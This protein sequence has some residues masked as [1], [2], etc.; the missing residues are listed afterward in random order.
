MDWSHPPEYTPGGFCFWGR[1]TMTILIRLFFTALLIPFGTMPSFATPVDL[2]HFLELPAAEVSPEEMAY[3]QGIEELAGGDLD[4]AENAFQAALAQRADYANALLGL[5]EIESRRNRPQAAGKRIEQAVAA[6]PDNVHAQLSLGRYLSSTGDY[7]G[8]EAA[9]LM[10]TELDPT[11]F[12]ARIDLADLYATQLNRPTEAVAAYR[13]AL[14][15]NPDH[16]GAHYAIGILL[17]RQGQTAEAEAM[18]TR[19]MQLEPANPLP[20]MGLARLYT[21]IGNPASALE[22]VDRALAIQPSLVQAGALRG[23]ILLAQGNQLAAS[24]QFDQLLRANPKSG[25]L[26]LRIGMLYQ[27]A[28]RI[29]AAAQAYRRAIRIDPSLA[30]AFNN[31]AWLAATEGKNLSQAEQ[32]A[33][34]AVTLAPNQPTFRDTLGWVY[35]AQGRL[36]DAEKTL[37]AAAKMAPQSSEIHYHLGRVYLDL[38]DKQ[39]ARQALEHALSL[40]DDFQ[41]SAEAR[42]LLEGL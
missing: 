14:D 17:A 40:S 28:G 12:R 3:R 34:R 33:R 10:A 24:Q 11:L 5:A 22:S 21:A 25:S 27:G 37:A 26:A 39:K 23:E 6:E 2:P 42:R 1:I 15:L 20:P 31:L 38:G 35:R 36:G 7:Q 13:A 9:L 41:E 30:L 4:G 29:E 19:A 8:A 16:A 32:W 18:L